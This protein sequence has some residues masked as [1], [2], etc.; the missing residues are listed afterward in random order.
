MR[1]KIE[2]KAIDQGKDYPLFEI[3]ADWRHRKSNLRPEPDGGSFKE[4]ATNYEAIVCGKCWS[5]V[6]CDA[7]SFFFPY[8][9]WFHR[10]KGITKYKAS[11]LY[12]WHLLTISSKMCTFY[13]IFH[14]FIHLSLQISTFDNFSRR[15]SLDISILK[16]VRH[17]SRRTKTVD[18]LF[19]WVLFVS[20][21][22]LLKRKRQAWPSNF[23]MCQT[24]GH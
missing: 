9:F 21:M 13:V 15:L 8:D 2:H 24:W 4:R 18:S 6:I 5:G 17:S 10:K 20:W 16:T 12:F 11:N 1:N 3:E 23:E 22:N 19:F 14:Y 7:M